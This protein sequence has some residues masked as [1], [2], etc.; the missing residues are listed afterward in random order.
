LRGKW[1]DDEIL[2][3]IN[4]TPL[5]DIMLVLLIIFMVTATI[6]LTPSIPVD[7]PKASTAEYPSARVYALVLDKEGNLYLN[8]K[9]TSAERISLALREAVKKDPGIQAIV[10]ADGAVDY[11]SVIR[12]IDLVKSSG[13][14]SFALNVQK[15]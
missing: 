7:L 2:T 10:A 11:Q 14:K 9:N 3:D 5:V 6:M 15:E 1:D 13:V 12:L 4:V 8:G